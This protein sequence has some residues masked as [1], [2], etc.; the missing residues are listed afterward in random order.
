MSA[1]DDTFDIDIYGDDAEQQ[2]PEETH[3]QQQEEDLY[4]EEDGLDG[5]NEDATQRQDSSAQA[6]TV[7]EDIDTSEVKPEQTSPS[8]EAQPNASK[9]ATPQPPPQQGTKRKKSSEDDDHDYDTSHPVVDG[10]AVQLDARPTDPGAMPALKLADLHWWTTEDDLRAFCARASVEEEL[11]E[12]SFGEHK[13][14]GKSRGDAYLEFA[15]PAAATAAKREIE[16]GGKEETGVRRTPFSVFFTAVGDPFKTG[17]GVGGGKKEFVSQGNARGGAYNSQGFVNRGNFGGGRGGGFNQNR[18]G[19]GGF[20]NNGGMYNSPRPNTQQ[21]GWGNMN[22][23]GMAAGYNAGGG[24]GGNFGGANP[25]MGGMGM[26]GMGMGMGMNRGGMMGNMMGRGGF[27]GMAGMGM[28]R[29]G[30]MGNM[31]NMMGR[32][33]WGGGGGGGFQGM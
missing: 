30:M 32:G 10:F 18:G 11:R 19:G 17:P 24:Y 16:K 13:I 8:T 21:G 14:N 29:G 27:G 15:S 31:G 2:L 23:N 26:G 5:N 9:T 4:A 22:G 1:D 28:N 25:M 33:G 12:L 3:E 6:H 20:N 7:A